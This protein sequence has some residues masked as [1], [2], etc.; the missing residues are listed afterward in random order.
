MS[1]NG[2]QRTFALKR[3]TLHEHKV[4]GAGFMGKYKA[5]MKNVADSRLWSDLD[6]LL[7]WK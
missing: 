6:E 4:M 7:F 1:A 3:E 5:R 2:Q